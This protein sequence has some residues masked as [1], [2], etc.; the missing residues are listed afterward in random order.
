MLSV[1]I[2]IRSIANATNCAAV[3]YTQYTSPPLPK[4]NSQAST[5]CKSAPAL[6]CSSATM[7]SARSPSVSQAAA[8]SKREVR[9]C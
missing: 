2:H 4:I 1:F 9:S 3:Y 7:R 6:W 5:V 8:A